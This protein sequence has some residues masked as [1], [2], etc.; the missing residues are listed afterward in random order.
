M[1]VTQEQ[2]DAQKLRVDG[3]NQMIADGVRQVTLGDQT[4]TYNTTDSLIRAR[5]DAQEILTA[6]EASL[7]G[8]ARVPRQTQLIYNGRGCW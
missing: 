8:T 2:I 6:M 5:D 7:A 1:A 4:I 3:L